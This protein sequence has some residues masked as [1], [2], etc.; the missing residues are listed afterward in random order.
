MKITNFAI[1]LVL[2]LLPMLVINNLNVTKLKQAMNEELRYNAALQTA[3]QDAAKTLTL[4]VNQTGEA[5][6]VSLRKFSANKEAAVRTFFHT[7][8]LNFG[9]KDDPIGERAL[10]EYVPLLIVVEYDGYSVYAPQ[11]YRNKDSQTELKHVWMP[12]KPYAYSDAAG[13]SLSFTLDDHVTAY[14][15]GQNLWEE[16][17]RSAV[18]SKVNIDLLKQP[19]TFEQVR[20]STIIQ[21]IQADLEHYINTYNSYAKRYGIHYTFTIPTISD[22]EWTNSINDIGIL[23]FLQGM[24]MS[25]DQMYNSYALG[26][27]RLVK[28]PVIYGTTDDG[29]KYYY[30]STCGFSYQP[31]ETFTTEKEAAKKGYHPLTCENGGP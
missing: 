10:Q 18:S 30:K 22:E 5:G 12:K 19:A 8:A 6:Y 13:N 23:A 2:L 26:G 17:K 14:D 11:E 15:R 21:L 7:L 25:G 16:G 24:P 20:R 31:E 27:A 9:V 1:L 4:N 3:A 28:K 29:I